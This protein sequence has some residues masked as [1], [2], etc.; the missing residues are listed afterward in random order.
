M[1]WILRITIIICMNMG[2]VVQSAADDLQV[3]TFQLFENLTMVDE[4]NMPYEPGYK[5]DLPRVC[6]ISNHTADRLIREYIKSTQNGISPNDITRAVSA[7]TP[8]IPLYADHIGN[9][10]GIITND[11]LTEFSQMAT[12]SDAFVYLFC[13]ITVYYEQ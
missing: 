9:D 5:D 13:I 11:E 4:K 2:I 6:R 1:E 12:R 10:D 8:K 3:E 7:V